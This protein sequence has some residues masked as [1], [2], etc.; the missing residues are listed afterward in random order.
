MPSMFAPGKVI[1]SVAA[2]CGP[3]F[4]VRLGSCREVSSVGGDCVRGAGYII[5]MSIVGAVAVI[6]RIRSPL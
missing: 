5:G 1:M 4:R 3:W 2:A 6:C